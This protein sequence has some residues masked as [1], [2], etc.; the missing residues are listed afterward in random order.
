MQTN[1]LIFDPFSRQLYASIPSVATGIAGNSIVPVNPFNGSVGTPVSV[2]SEPDPLSETDDGNYLWVGLDGAS[3]L[4]KFNLLTQTNDATVPVV[5]SQYGQ[6]G[7]TSAVAI[8]AQPGSETTLAIETSNIGNIGIFDVTGS[9]GSFRPNLSGIYAGNI[10]VFGDSAHVYAHDDYTSGNEFYAYTVDANGLTQIYNYTFLDFGDYAGNSFM[11]G[12]NGLAYSAL[13]GIV[14]PANPPE[15]VAVL[16]LSIIGS[17]FAVVPDTA[18][19]FVFIVSGSNGPAQP[20]INRFQLGNFVLDTAL[21]LPPSAD[22]QSVQ[23]NAVHF[24]QDGLALRVSPF[25][26]ENASTTDYQIL[27][28]RGPLMLPAE[29]LTNPAPALTGTSSSTIAVNSGNQY[30]AV[31]GS[32]FMPGAVVLWNGSARTTTFIDSGHLKAAIPASDVAAA[33]T[34]ALTAD[35]PGSSSS[36]SITVTVQ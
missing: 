36:N 23:Y 2:G 22:G 33:A 35:N 11:I 30:L 17:G 14:N 9:T 20:A 12:A 18:Q 25:Q 5:I 24:G 8:A 32:G 6:T 29:A 21:N 7:S 10:P 27:L 1:S 3:S 28:F 31:T 19:G 16:P 15:Q 34:I 13:G 4:A 26:Y